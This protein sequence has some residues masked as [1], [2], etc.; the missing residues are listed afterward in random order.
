MSVAKP[1]LYFREDVA[2]LALCSRGDVSHSGACP[3]SHWTDGGTSASSQ[4]SA[5]KMSAN[6]TTGY[7]TFLP[8]PLPERQAMVMAPPLRP[9]LILSL[10]RQE[11]TCLQCTMHLIL[12][13]FS[14]KL[15]SATIDLKH[16]ATVCNCLQ[17][18]QQSTTL[19]S[20]CNCLDSLQLPWQF[21]TVWIGHGLWCI[22]PCFLWKRKTRTCE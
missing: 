5:Q 13:S 9:S 11:Y 18:S 20:V 14:L 19:L 10:T 15:C 4:C 2:K 7:W 21:V 3:S 17:L 1:A 12:H 8:W 6:S 22:G 16:S